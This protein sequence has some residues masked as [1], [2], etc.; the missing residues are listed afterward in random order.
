MPQLSFDCLLPPLNASFPL[1][2]FLF[3]F[4]DSVF[5]YPLCLVSALI[6]A[7]SSPQGHTGEATQHQAPQYYRIHFYFYI[8]ESFR[9]TR[10]KNL[11]RLLPQRQTDDNGS[12]IRVHWLKH[13]KEKETSEPPRVNHRECSTA[14][15]PRAPS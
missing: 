1:F 6:P 2:G 10:R 4:F 9:K 7:H 14:S 12:V 15:A 13:S 11:F 8:H 5:W 3:L